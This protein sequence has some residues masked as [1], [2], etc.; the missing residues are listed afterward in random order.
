MRG[1]MTA[2]TK[3]IKLYEPVPVEIMTEYVKYELP[4][5]RAAASLLMLKIQNSSLSC[6]KPKPS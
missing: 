5:P 1:I 6:F 3:P 2:R 4:K